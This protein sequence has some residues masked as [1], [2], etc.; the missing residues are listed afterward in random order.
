VDSRKDERWSQNKILSL[1]TAFCKA[2]KGNPEGTRARDSFGTQKASL[3]FRT[4]F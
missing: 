1:H 4:S 2:A 3:N